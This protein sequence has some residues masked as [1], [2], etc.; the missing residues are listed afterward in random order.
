M[1][2]LDRELEDV[3]NI[4]EELSRGVLPEFDTINDFNYK[5]VVEKHFKARVDAIKASGNLLDYP[6]N[7]ET[8]NPALQ[9]ALKTEQFREKLNKEIGRAHV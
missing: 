9:E 2:N 4:V 5:D 3:R 6:S 1:P 7:Y 8:D